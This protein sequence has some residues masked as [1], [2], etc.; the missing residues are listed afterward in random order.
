MRERKRDKEGSR[1]KERERMP[2]QHL[3]INTLLSLVENPFI[4]WNTSC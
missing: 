4:K 1:E 3:S 2:G